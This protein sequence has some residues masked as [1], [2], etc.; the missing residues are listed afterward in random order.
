MNGGWGEGGDAHPLLFT[1]DSSSSPQKDTLP[2]SPNSSMYLF[3]CSHILQNEV[4]RK[5]YTFEGKRYR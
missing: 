5:L 3:I 4:D 1:V 2:W